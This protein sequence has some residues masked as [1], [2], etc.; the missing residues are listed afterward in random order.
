MHEDD[1]L[2]SCEQDNLQALVGHVLNFKLLLAYRIGYYAF[3]EDL[4][5]RSC[6]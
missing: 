6:W 2:R 4:I 5:S 1:F 3:A